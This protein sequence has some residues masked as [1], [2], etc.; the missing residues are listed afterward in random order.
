MPLPSAGTILVLPFIVGLIT[1]MMVF[2][3]LEKQKDRE[4]IIDDDDDDDEKPTTPFVSLSMAFL[5]GFT[6]SV[7]CG[8]YFLIVL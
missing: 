3:G 1:T 6:S 4:V 5:G 2:Y 7:I 8:G